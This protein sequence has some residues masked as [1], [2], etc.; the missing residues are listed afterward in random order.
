MSEITLTKKQLARIKKDM[1]EQVEMLTDAEVNAL[2]KS[3]NKAFNLPFLNEKK[4]FVVFVK[5]IKWV[6]YQLYQILPNEYYELVKD[7]TDGISQ[8]EAVKLEERLTPLINNVV[9][10]PIISER[11]EAKL[12]SLVLGLIIRAMIKGYKLEEAQPE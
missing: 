8:E 7:A 5:V 10:I 4:E 3:I 6:D 9:N 1:S 12:I 2:A 11:Q